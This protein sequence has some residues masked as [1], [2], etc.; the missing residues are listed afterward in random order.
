MTNI[1]KTGVSQLKHQC[2]RT[3]CLWPSLFTR[4]YYNYYKSA[5]VLTCAYWN[6][7]FLFHSQSI[8]FGGPTC[9][10]IERSS[11]IPKW[12]KR[13][14]MKWWVSSDHFGFL[15]LLNCKLLLLNFSGWRD[16]RRENSRKTSVQ[17]MSP[18]TVD[19]EV[20]DLSHCRAP[21]RITNLLLE[22]AIHYCEKILRHHSF[23]FLLA[24]PIYA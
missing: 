10:L 16:A 5:V 2:N 9:L 3:V 12:L 23:L 21:W 7:T 20:K 22:Y 4:E 19:T 17:E 14:R 6:L 1:I 11:L 8:H 24:T 18:E 15:Q 13:G